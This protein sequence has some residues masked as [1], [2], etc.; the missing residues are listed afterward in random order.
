MVV[1]G[2]FAFAAQRSGYPT[3]PLILGF[4]LAN[5]V[6]ANFHRALAVGFGSYS[7]FF[8]RPISLGMI[9]AVCAL[10]T[11]SWIRS[12]RNVLPEFETSGIGTG[13]FLFAGLVTLILLIFLF[14]AFRYSSAVR[15]FPV[16][17]STT[18]LTL[19]AYWFFI[20]FRS[21]KIAPLTLNPFS[22]VWLG[23][24]VAYALLVPVV[25]FIVASA[26]FFLLV[27]F[28]SRRRESE[29]R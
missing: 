2:V 19:T 27:I 3:V 20:A 14:S 6:E 28:I 8:V 10:F 16:I 22:F 12:R 9:V 29:S 15:L 13:E 18:G 21:K 11:W 7:I 24:L 26:V 23:L 1:L 5:L 25:G 4:I 17:V